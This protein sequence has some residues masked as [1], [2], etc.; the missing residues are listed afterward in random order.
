MIYLLVSCT[1]AVEL[2]VMR[3]VRLFLIALFRQ[4]QREDLLMTVTPFTR[5]FKFQMICRT[6]AYVDLK[7]LLG[8]TAFSRES[9][10][11]PLDAKG[12]PGHECFAEVLHRSDCYPNSL[13]ALIMNAFFGCSK[14]GPLGS[15]LHFLAIGSL[16]H[17]GRPTIPG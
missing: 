13:R 15:L 11:F 14:R 16:C 1:V 8:S 17:Q 6:N 12:R 3:Y 4:R 7:S 5:P 2:C 9:D 10:R